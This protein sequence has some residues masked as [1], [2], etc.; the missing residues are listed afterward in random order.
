MYS[1]EKLLDTSIYGPL[2]FLGIPGYP[3]QRPPKNGYVKHTPKF[4]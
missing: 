3:N 4:Q 2:E 1:V